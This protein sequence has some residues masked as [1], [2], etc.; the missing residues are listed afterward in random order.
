M[1]HTRGTTNGTLVRGQN[2]CIYVFLC[3]MHAHAGKLSEVL[4]HGQGS[5]NCG[6]LC[7]ALVRRD[8]QKFCASADVAGR[9]L[10]IMAA[11]GR[12]GASGSTSNDAELAS[13]GGSD[14]AAW[15]E[16]LDAAKGMSC[17]ELQLLLLT[18]ATA[19]AGYS[20]GICERRLAGAR[21]GCLGVHVPF[22]MNCSEV[23]P[24]LGLFGE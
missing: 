10:Q 20:S 22:Q 5:C 6:P 8:A 12:D 3:F 4:M 16:P 7:P 24:C 13:G 17:G 14:G 18:A 2:A 19:Y 21:S 15:H 1:G 9:V 23:Y 11:A